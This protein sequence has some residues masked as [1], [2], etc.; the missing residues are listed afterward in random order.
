M[1]GVISV[2]EHLPM[3]LVLIASSSTTAGSPVSRAPAMMGWSADV[4][5]PGGAISQ[6][7][8]VARVRAA[9]A[10]FEPTRIMRMQVPLGKRVASPPTT[11][12]CF[13]PRVVS[14][15]RR[16]PHGDARRVH[17]SRNPGH[18]QR[19]ARKQAETRGFFPRRGQNCPGATAS[20]RAAPED[21]LAA[22]LKRERGSA[23]D[24]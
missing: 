3:L 7:D 16:L 23:D 4:S 12:R 5:S 2:A 21:L 1:R 17:Y 14:G 10:T 6:P 9:P 18:R 13:D 24:W 19:K 11:P 22:V 8:K 15:G 20:A